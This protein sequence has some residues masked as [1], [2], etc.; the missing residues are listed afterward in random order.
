MF[1]SYRENENRYQGDGLYLR[2]VFEFF[3]YFFVVFILLLSY[4][5][6]SKVVYFETNAKIQIKNF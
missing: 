5:R 3:M 4:D 6:R 2:Q 1:Q